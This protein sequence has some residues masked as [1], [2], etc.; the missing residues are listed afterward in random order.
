MKAKERDH[1]Y[2]IMKC[3]G[4]IAVIVGHLT[5]TG[6]RCIYSW[7]MPLF[8]IIAGYFYHEKDIFVMARKDA[9]RLLIPY[10]LTCLAIILC[11]TFKS[12]RCDEDMVSS[13]IVAALYANGSPNHS[14]EYLANIPAIGAIWFLWAMFWTKNIFNIIFKLYKKHLLLI[15][16]LI[17]IAAISTDRYVINLPLAI[18]PG[19]SATLF[20]A[21]GYKARQINNSAVTSKHLIYYVCGG[22]ISAWIISFLFYDMSMARCYFENLPVNIIGACGGTLCVK[23]ISGHLS[24]CKCKA[25]DLAEWI[26]RNSMVF[27]CI[28]A[29]DMCYSIRN[30]ID[31]SESG[32]ILFVVFYC[33][34]GTYIISFIPFTRR[35]FGIR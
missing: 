30:H 13:W 21:I 11:F 28:H 22:G 4:I 18:L 20:Y 14:S 7:H 24:E 29:C 8:F 23:I 27:L 12:L 32:N 19:I 2:D 33:I 1:T 25:T 3:I 6:N 17:S 31:L 34:L 35:I 5:D 9:K 26:G 16:L 10:Y 15:C